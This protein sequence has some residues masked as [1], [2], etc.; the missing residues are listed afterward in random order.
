MNVFK[1]NACEYGP[2]YC[3]TVPRTDADIYGEG[4]DGCPHFCPYFGD[5]EQPEFELVLPEVRLNTRFCEEMMEWLGGE[6]YD[7]A[8]ETLRDA[9]LG[10]GMNPK[11]IDEGKA[12]QALRII[13]QYDEE[14]LYGYELEEWKREFDKIKKIDLLN[15][16][17]PA[18]FKA[19]IIFGEIERQKREAK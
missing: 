19:G 3:Q 13:Q 9:I 10:F 16:I 7:N 1:C 5:Q 4:D 17:F 8:P 12:L 14:H 11:G 2:C 15:A 6:G 18:A